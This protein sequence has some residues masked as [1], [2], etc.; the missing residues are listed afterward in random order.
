MSASLGWADALWLARRRTPNDRL[1]YWGS[2]ASSAIATA[3]LCTA[4]GL[5]AQPGTSLPV[6]IRV[7]AEWGTRGGAAFAV[8]LVAL[9]ALHLTGQTWKLGSI[10]RRERMRQLRDAGAGPSDLRRVAMADTVGPVLIGG[11]AG[12]VLLGVVLGL[13]NARGSYLPG[14]VE[15]P[16]GAMV[17]S[18][19]YVLNSGMPVVPNVVTAAWWPAPLAIALVALGASVAAARAVARFDRQPTRTRAPGG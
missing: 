18:G 13:L 1:R 12:V 17:P 7:V 9:P 3:L 19:T 11:V 10:E 6:S 5:V 15:G 14:Y 16:G 8:L 4:A 2:M